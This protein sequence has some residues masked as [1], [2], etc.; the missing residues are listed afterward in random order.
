M[1]DIFGYEGI[2]HNERSLTQ[3]LQVISSNSEVGYKIRRSL[4]A[5]YQVWNTKPQVF[6]RTKENKTS[7]V[8]VLYLQ[9]GNCRKIPTNNY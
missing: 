8:R 5:D 6:R 1:P 2:L 4:S 9:R 3:H 7:Y